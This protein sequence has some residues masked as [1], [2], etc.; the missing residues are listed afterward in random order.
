LNEYEVPAAFERTCSVMGV[1]HPVPLPVPESV[2]PS[3]PISAKNAPHV[4]AG[5]GSPTGVLLGSTPPAGTLPDQSASRYWFWMFTRPPSAIVHFAGRLRIDA[6]GDWP[7][8]I[9][10]STS[11]ASTAAVSA[12]PRA[13][14]VG[15]S[16]IPT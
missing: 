8:G 15:G 9:V 11:V 10:S 2:T 14:A 12:L 4:F 1:S 13:P 6:I 7:T 3:W 5:Y 16:S